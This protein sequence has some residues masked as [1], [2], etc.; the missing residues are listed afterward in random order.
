MFFKAEADSV[1]LISAQKEVQ[2]AKAALEKERE[3]NDSLK[4][5][6][7][8]K[9]SKGECV[10]ILENA[11]D[12]NRQLYKIGKTHDL[13]KRESNYGTPYPD[14][15]NIVHCRHCVNADLVEK[16]MHHVLKGY[17]YKDNEEWFK[18]DAKLF[19]KML[20]CIIHFVDGLAEAGDNVVACD[21]DKKIEKLMHRVKSFDPDE[22][23]Y[24]SDASSAASVTINNNVTVM[25]SPNAN[26]YLSTGGDPSCAKFIDDVVRET[27]VDLDRLLQ[28]DLYRAFCDWNVR[29][30]TTKVPPAS[31]TLNKSMEAKG[32]TKKKSI[33]P[34][35][36]YMH[37]IPYANTEEPGTGYCGVTLRPFWQDAKIKK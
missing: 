6:L 26:V 4:R 13:S 16:N 35:V 9:H 28:A 33:R 8:G 31:H 17:R 37:R 34:G 18:G 7:K 10:Y 19:A 21:L 15:S 1:K 20:D 24:H 12:A 2:D 14:G 3:K 27:K 32:F 5:K 23:G 22:E 30:A 29:T 25:D 36:G 11:A